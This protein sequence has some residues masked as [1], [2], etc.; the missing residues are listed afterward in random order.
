MSGRRS[1]A[2]RSVR[3]L[4]PL[5]AA[6]T[7]L[8][9]ATCGP[10]AA[11]PAAHALTTTKSAT[12]S[13]PPAAA[14]NPLAGRPWGVYKGPAEMSWSP[15]TKASGTNR[16]LLAKIALRPKATW[17]GAWFSSANIA[18][19]VR[20]YI[21]NSQAGNPNALVQMTVFRMVPWEGDACHRLPTAAEQASYKQWTDRFAS[22]VGN[23]HV[24]IIL[25]PDGP[26]A[27][28]A[29]GH[30]LVP[31]HLIA[32]SARV[33]SALPHT[34]VYIE[35]GEADW[36][37][38]GQGGVSAALRILL[39]AGIQ[40]ARG[41]ALN[42][43]HYSSTTDEVARGAAI[44]KALA[45]RGIRGKHVVINT[46]SNGHPFVF[47]KYTGPDPDNAFVCRS[48]TDNRTCVKLGISPTTDVAN[49]CW[50]LSAA[51]NQLARTY[52]DAYMWFGRPWLYRQ[53]FP[54]D[55]NRA[56]QLARTSLY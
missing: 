29:P 33:F 8:F 19:E 45:A 31:S 15:Y 37:A 40:Y 55:T 5:V 30:S 11:M 2:L 25:Q 16:A 22:A 43:T 56:L 34:S 48:A 44:V 24:A 52:V 38:P 54:F 42:G 49:P 9:G 50:R 51:T 14:G 12:V 17:F 32:Y 26:F 36:P 18:S 35:A 39:P 1:S 23:A 3:G 13:A 47:G 21:A 20:R 28:C 53:A 46:S 4:P 10:S 7:L 41:V 6:A 27:L